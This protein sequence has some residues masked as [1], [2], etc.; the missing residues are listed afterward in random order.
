MR[1]SP[2]LAA[3]VV[4][5]LL[6]AGLLTGLGSGRAGLAA[7]AAVQGVTLTAAPS[8]GVAPLPVSFTLT[9]PPNSSL[10]GLAWSFGD[11]SYLNGTG[12]SY[13]TPE[14]AYVLAGEFV[15]TA[16]VLWPSGTVNVSVPIDVLTANVTVDLRANLT[17]GV[18]PLTVQFN[19]TAEGGTGTFVAFTW[20]FGNGESGLGASVRYTFPKAGDYPVEL[21]VT[22]SRGDE[23]RAVRWINVSAPAN[24]S[25]ATVPRPASGDP[26]AAPVHPLGTSAPSGGEVAALLAGAAV[27]LVGVYFGLGSARSRPRT[28]V[29]PGTGG[30]GPSPPMV[31]PASAAAIQPETTILGTG[32]ATPVPAPLRPV[33]TR[34]AGERQIAN[35][36]VRYLAT[37]PRLAPGEAAEVGRTQGGM[38]AALD[39]GQSAVS[40]VLSQLERAGVVSVATDHVAGSSRRVKVYRLT[41][42]GERLGTALREVGPRP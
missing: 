34:L 27:A 10:P 32:S 11:G 15:A 33:P 38:A 19:G 6:A 1:F 12:T 28:R 42:H 16:P 41:P 24:R 9:L 7:P 18:A 2:R 22:D 29:G 13:L 20:S 14:H 17:T 26:S 5:A 25:N 23:G 21:V 3:A 36:V 37:L 4:V 30:P 35:R 40:R 31:V 8:S 39:V